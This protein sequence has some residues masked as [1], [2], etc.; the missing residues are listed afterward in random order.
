MSLAFK[1]W[2]LSSKLRRRATRLLRSQVETALLRPISGMVMIMC[3]ATATQSPRTVAPG[4]LQRT[5]KK[6]HRASR[7]AMIA[8]RKEAA[9]DV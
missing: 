1:K 8:I 3:L 7:G 4:A 9:P 5:R 6:E 2:R